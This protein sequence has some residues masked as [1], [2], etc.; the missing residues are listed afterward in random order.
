[1]TTKRLICI[2]H[3]GAAGYLPENTLP[4][5]ERAVQL[6]CDWVELDVH[7]VGNELLVIHDEQVERTT[8]GKGVI[9]ALDL[10]YIRSLDAGGGAGVPTLSEVIDMIDHRCGINIELKGDNTADAVSQQLNDYCARGWD[11]AEFLISSFQHQELAKVAGG[12][13]RGALFVSMT[14]DSWEEVARLDA[15]SVHLLAESVH[16]AIV[17]EAHARGYQLLVYT[18]NDPEDMRRLAGYG[19]DGFFS[20]FPDRVLSANR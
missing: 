4:S 20:D 8:N 7:R 13:R 11:R 10:A 17:D 3:R 19:V 16:Q 15:W 5:F 9:S 14:E 18:V 12:Y 2:G 6:G 1:M